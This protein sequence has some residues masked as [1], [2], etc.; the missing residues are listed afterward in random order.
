ML[1]RK[2]GEKLI[3]ERSYGMGRGNIKMKREKEKQAG[4]VAVSHI[5]MIIRIII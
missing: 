2:R 5:M 1:I 4:K 3:Q